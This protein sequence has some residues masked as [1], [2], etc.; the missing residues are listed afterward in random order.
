MAW[1]HRREGP[2]GVML[3]DV[4][5]GLMAGAVTAALAAVAHGWLA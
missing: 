4:V 3:G 5:A 1:A 2:T